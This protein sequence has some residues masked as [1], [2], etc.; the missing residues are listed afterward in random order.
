MIGTGN[1]TPHSRANFSD[2]HVGRRAG[3]PRDRIQQAN[4]GFKRGADLLDLGIEASQRLVEAVDLTSQLGPHKALLSF[5][6]AI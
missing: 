5:D 2:D 1:A 6:S 4:R 3:H